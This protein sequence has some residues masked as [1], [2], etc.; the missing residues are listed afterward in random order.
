MESLHTI[1]KSTTPRYSTLGKSVVIDSD[2]QLDPWLS[3]IGTYQTEMTFM[4][5]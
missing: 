4:T 3:A 1:Q 5:M 2:S